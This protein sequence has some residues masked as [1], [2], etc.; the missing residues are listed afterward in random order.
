MT[1]VA[2]TPMRL[3][4]ALGPRHVAPARRWAAGFTAVGALVTAI[5][6]F[7]APGPLGL[8]SLEVIVSVS[9]LVLVA[10][11]LLLSEP[12]AAALCVLTPILGVFSIALL[13]VTT[14]DASAA[15]QIFFC[16]PVL[17]AATQLRPAGAILVTASA[18]AGHGVVTL[19]VLPFEK[20]LTDLVYVGTT[21]ALTAGL[22]T[23]A[24]VTNDR[25]ISRLR[26]Q[27]AIDPL[28]GLVTRRVLDDAC[29]AA[30]SSAGPRSGTALILMDVDLFKSVNDTHGHPV[31]DDALTHIAGVLAVHS[32]ADD[33]IARMGGDEIAVLLPGCTYPVALRRAEE[34]VA[35]VR[36][37]PLIL[38]TGQI[39]E[40]S[41]SAG[42]A[43]A[44][45][46]GAEVRELYASADAALYVAKHAGRG[47]VGE[48]H[49]PHEPALAA[50]AGA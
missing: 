38:G 2:V 12:K 45:D 10:G 47:R 1:F 46:A 42:V 35:A 43:H 14:Q 39:L 49:E 36:D 44:P 5:F 19:S 37:T 41:V 4:R 27:A 6:A 30:I 29:R 23:R 24:G 7:L 11:L 28:T 18:V 50:S 34:F 20:G 33:V 9:M 8:L 3:L 32:R 13:D 16:L 25:L 40:L 22:L 21:L 48:V 31:G 26:Q 17:F 15:A